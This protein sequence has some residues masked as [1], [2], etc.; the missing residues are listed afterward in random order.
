M[1]QD[2]ADLPALDD[3]ELSHREIMLA[4]SGTM[5]GMFVALLSGAIVINALPRIVPELGGSQTGY[6][7]SSSR[8]SSP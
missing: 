5:L 1:S 7:W 4:M 2:L 8:A 6:T 3:G